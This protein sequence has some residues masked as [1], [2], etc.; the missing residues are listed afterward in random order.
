[1]LGQV[2][3]TGEL[4]MLES[5]VES[6]LYSLKKVGAVL[7]FQR[8]HARARVLPERRLPRLPLHAH[9]RQGRLLRVVRSQKENRCCELF[10]GVCIE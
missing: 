3:I 2:L 8:L 6:F 9:R 1:M 10:L 7:D 5:V 4:K